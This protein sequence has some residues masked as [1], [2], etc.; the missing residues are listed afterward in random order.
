MGYA[1]ILVLKRNQLL[2]TDT[3]TTLLPSTLVSNAIPGYS[4]SLLKLQK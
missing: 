4:L 2:Y 3:I 1:D